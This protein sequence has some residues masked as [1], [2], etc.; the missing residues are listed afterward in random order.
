MA[1]DVSGKGLITDFTTSLAFC[2]RLP[3]VHSAG[4]QGADIARASWA[5]PLAGVVVGALGA[6]VYWIADGLYLDPIL[7]SILAVAATVLITGALHEDGLADTADGF[8]ARASRER[9][10]DIMS[11]SEIGTYGTSALILSFMLR[12]G[13]L[14]SLAEPGLAAAALIA[15]NAGARATLPVFMRRVPHARQDGLSAGVGEPPQQSA[16]IA[17]LLGLLVLLL[18]LGLGATLAAG[19]VLAC[20]GGLMAWLCVTQIGGQT[21]DVIGALE[22]VSEILILLVAAA[23]L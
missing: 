16:A 3:L 11:D 8:G 5:F 21:G 10:L 18:C 6:L 22:Q 1:G 12:T 14:V 7:S 20:A 15:A 23:W 2:T 13:A 17:V 19:F 9:K 4:A